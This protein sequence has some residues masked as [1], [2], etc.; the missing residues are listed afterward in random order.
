VTAESIA[1]AIGGRRAGGSFSR[2]LPVPKQPVFRVHSGLERL[3][4]ADGV[5]FGTHRIFLSVCK[6]PLEGCDE[7][8]EGAARAAAFQR[9]RARRDVRIARAPRGA[10][11]NHILFGRSPRIENAVA[12]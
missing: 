6:P 11:F 10:D 7:L 12:R 1:G 9:K 4:G 3:A 2:R 8:G 5:P